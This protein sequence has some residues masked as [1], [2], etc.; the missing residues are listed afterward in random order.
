MVK[1]LRYNTITPLLLELLQA[2]MESEELK[3]FRL[4]G[5]TA[6]SLQRGHRIS[7]DIDLFTDVVYGSVDFKKIDLFLRNRWGYVDTNDTLPI[8]FGKSYFIGSNEDD[9]VKLDLYYTDPFV[10]ELCLI[11]GIRFASI[12]EIIAMKVDVILRGGR[13]KDSSD[14]HELLNDYSLKS[15]LSS[16]KKRYP[17]TYNR[18]QILKQ[19]IDFSLADDDFD[20]ICLLGK[21]WEIIKLD[22]T[23]QVS[24][25]A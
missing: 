20:P 22:I 16:Y 7:I 11:E 23:D 6:L 12:E 24:Q 1:K 15:M 10:Y 5:G 8:A 14:I 21:H 2:L 17:Y 18:K 19:F 13:K 9:C 4:V 25:E 3:M